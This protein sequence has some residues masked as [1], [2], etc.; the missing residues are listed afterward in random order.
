[1]VDPSVS[2]L[3]AINSLLVVEVGSNFL[4]IEHDVY[5]LS[6]ITGFNS[7]CPTTFPDKSYY[8]RAGSLYA[9]VETPLFTFEMWHI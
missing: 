7:Y 1:M 3:T 8:V 4:E 6:G 5:G 9:V 2:S